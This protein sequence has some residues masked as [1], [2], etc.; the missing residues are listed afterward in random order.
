MNFNEEMELELSEFDK[1]K[2]EI[3]PEDEKATVEDWINLEKR[4]EL[5]VHENEAMMSQSE[6][7]AAR[8]AL[9]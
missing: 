3:I 4:I 5:C 2:L 6:L 1:G 9:C 7:N 8:S